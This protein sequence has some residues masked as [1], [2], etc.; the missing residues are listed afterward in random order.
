MD[1][2]DKKIAILVDNYFEQT[3]FEQ[4]RDALEKAGAK[5]SIVAAREKDLRGLHH[6]EK[7]D[8]FQADV[9]LR[10]A[11]AND[12]DALVLPGGVVNAD[13]LRVSKDA[14]AWARDFLE[15]GRPVAA[16]CH[17][18]WLLVSAKLLKGRHVTS[19][20]TIQDDIKNAGATWTDEPV[21]IDNNLITS[22]Q[23][24]DLPD[25]IEA[26]LRLLREEEEE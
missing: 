2:T 15:S 12:Y 11:S 7:G 10:D 16:I 20:F 24:E 13:S 23:P 19:Y 1:I 3:E 5:V 25:F 22:R 21:V 4:P 14:Q 18:P 26:I 17:A 8:A 9:L 6:A